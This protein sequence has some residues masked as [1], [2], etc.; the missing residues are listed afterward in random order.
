MVMVLVLVVL[1]LVGGG[2]SPELAGCRGWRLAG[3]RRFGIHARLGKL[4]WTPTSR[5]IRQNSQMPQ[6][7][8]KGQRHE[9][10]GQS[11]SAALGTRTT[12]HPSPERAIQFC[13]RMEVH[14]EVVGCKPNSPPPPP[15][16]RSWG[17]VMDLGRCQGFFDVHR[18]RADHRASEFGL[19]PKRTYSDFD[20]WG[21]AAR[22]R[23]RQGFAQTPNSPGPVWRATPTSAHTTRTTDEPS[24]RDSSPNPRLA[25]Q[26][27]LTSY[28]IN[29]CVNPMDGWHQTARSTD[30]RLP[31]WWGW[32]LWLA[33]AARCSVAAAHRL[34]A[35]TSARSSTWRPSSPYATTKP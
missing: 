14:I 33:T 25:D 23:C 2:D 32:L 21:V 31:S 34:A 5:G 8:P 18:G 24:R 11:A 20:S 28:R 6:F 29:T 19:R 26:R 16:R 15:T 35:P 3:F 1:V 9:S 10:P 30:G 17:V 13:P 4:G 27:I 12:N 7:A 22:L